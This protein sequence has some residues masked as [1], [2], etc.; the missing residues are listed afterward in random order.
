MKL[1]L[2]NIKLSICIIGLIGF[3]PLSA[4]QEPSTK[5]FSKIIIGGN[6]VWNSSIGD[7]DEYWTSDNGLDGFIQT[8]FYAGDIKISF[9]YIPFKGKDEYHPDFNSYYINLGWK[10]NL[11]ITNDISLNVGAKIGSFMMSFQD[12]TLSAFRN[13]ESEIGVAAEAGIK[14]GVSSAIDIHFNANFLSVF[15]SRRIKLFNLF[16]GVSY[17]FTS[18]KWLRE[19]AE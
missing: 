9:T 6:F 10:E 18:P 11:N 17:A 1:I 16:A 14:F 13:Q 4:Q 5:A 7:L 8:L 3:V 2:H 12:D 15:T 19:I